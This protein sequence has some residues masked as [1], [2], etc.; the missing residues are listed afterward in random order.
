M[1]LWSTATT[2][3]NI[4][5]VRARTTTE[6]YA[7]DS[8][9]NLL[10]SIC[11]FYEI[12][13]IYPTKITL[14]S[15]TFKQHRFE[16]LHL[17]AIRY[18]ISNFEYRGIDPSTTITG[19]DLETSTKGEYTNSVVPFMS[20]PYGCHSDILLEKRKERNPFFRAAPYELTCP[21]MKILLKWCGP[22]L[23]DEED[24]PWSSF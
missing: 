20:D 8:F 21:D 1:N 3:H 22:D 6:E 23:I 13:H 10:F 9:Q 11:R 12:T 17:N 15:F 18:P 4:N 16:S 5:T 24:V 7:T 14:V 19:F 2:N